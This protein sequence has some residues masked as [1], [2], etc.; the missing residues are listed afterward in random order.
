MSFN[1]QFTSYK[2]RAKHQ[3]MHQTVKTFCCLTLCAAQANYHGSHHHEINSNGTKEDAL[4]GKHHLRAPGS[5]MSCAN[6]VEC[7]EENNLEPAAGTAAQPPVP[8][9]PFAY[10][11]NVLP[12]RVYMD[13]QGTSRT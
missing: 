2:A 11:E 13:V 5:T 1:I 3:K 8:Y 6:N 12:V 7:V 10:N 4:D 9:Q